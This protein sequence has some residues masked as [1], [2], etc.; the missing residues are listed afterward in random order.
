VFSLVFFSFSVEAS[1]VAA[2]QTMQMMVFSHFFT[3]QNERNPAMRRR[4]RRG[5]FER[6]RKYLSLSKVRVRV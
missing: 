2:M 6:A 5:H 4:R 3:T 1:S